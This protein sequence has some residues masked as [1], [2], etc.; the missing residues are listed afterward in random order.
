MQC[1]KARK[2]LFH[3]HALKRD[4]YGIIKLKPNL[5]VIYGLRGGGKTTLLFQRYLDYEKGK[6]VYFSGDELVLLKISIYEIFKNLKYAMDLGKDSAVLLMKSQSSKLGRRNKNCIRF[7]SKFTNLY[8]RFF[9]NRFSTIKTALARRA[10]YHHLLPMTFR[11]YVKLTRNIELEK[12][13]LFSGDVYTQII[14]YDI[15][16]ETKISNPME[17]FHEYMSKEPP[18]SIEANQDM[19]FDLVEK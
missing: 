9:H 3:I 5:K 1:L 17:L 18:I 15:Y 11:E 14:R 12:F 19:I 2:K 8:I 10:S 4:L 7:Q 6:R 13:D 16:L